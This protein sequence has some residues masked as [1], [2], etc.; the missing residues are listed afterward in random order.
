MTIRSDVS[1]PTDVALALDELGAALRDAAGENLL[2]LILYGGLARGRYNPGASDI[3]LVVVV[4]DA[5]VQAIA[6]LA[7]P[8]HAAWRGRRVEPLII[9]PREL[10]RLAIAFPT[11]I[12]DIQRRHIVL[13]GDDPFAGIEVSR[14]H[15][16][17][18]VEQELRNLA[19]RMRRRFVSIHE[20]AEALARAADDAAAPLAVNLRAL[21]YLKGI[22]S[23]EFQPALAIYERAAQAFGLDVEAL[24]ATKSIHR[25]GGE[26][27]LSTEL[28][29]RLLA[30][31]E[32]AADTAASLET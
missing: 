21:L 5:S 20:N 1:L 30:T 2:G 16:R 7:A 13:A 17:L 4:G 28:F 12:L 31:I 32:K 9:T 22:V 6:P 15:I 11:K 14:E 19:L 27:T 23:D 10:P 8:L 24:N 29:G 3:N 18:R 26:A 25:G